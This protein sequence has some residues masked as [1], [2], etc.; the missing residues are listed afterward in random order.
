[1]DSVAQAGLIILQV[2][3]RTHNK[4]RLTVQVSLSPDRARCRNI[5][6]YGNLM[7]VEEAER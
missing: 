4:D 7:A 6:S 1:M 3:L 2:G 5:T